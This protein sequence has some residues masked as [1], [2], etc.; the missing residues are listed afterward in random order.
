[1]TR[2]GIIAALKLEAA[3]LDRHAGF[4]IRVVGLGV[5]D[6]GDAVRELERLGSRLIVSWGTAGA[7]SPRL[8]AGDLLVPERVVT[9]NGGTVSPDRCARDGF[10]RAMNDCWPV[11][12]ETLIESERVLD[13][14]RDKRRL[15]MVT[16]AGAV[17]MESGRIGEACAALNLPFLAIRA[18][19]DELDDRLPRQVREGTFSAGSLRPGALLAGLARHPGDWG[20][21][22]RLALRYRRAR[23]ALEAAAQALARYA[24]SP[25]R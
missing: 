15:G 5:P 16:D 24:D 20:S 13:S 1:M 21:L 8:R 10:G 22:A 14:P 23:A 2:V 4:T 12:P 19:V 3:P 6:V 11:A 25:P 18:I 17:D 9:R 7:L